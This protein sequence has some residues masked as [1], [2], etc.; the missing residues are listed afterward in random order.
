M[1]SPSGLLQ[2]SPPRSA[3]GRR[4]PPRL[5]V[6]QSPVVLAAR[7][8]IVALQRLQRAQQVAWAEHQLAEA[9]ACHRAAEVS[10]AFE[11]KVKLKRQKSKPLL[12]LVS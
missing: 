6:P 10:M 7:S 2:D 12:A 9:A 4:S 3:G 8:K 5:G 1:E 11:E